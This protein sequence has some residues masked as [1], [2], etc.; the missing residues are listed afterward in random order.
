MNQSTAALLSRRLETRNSIEDTRCRAEQNGTV[1]ARASRLGSQRA[2]HTLNVTFMVGSVKGAALRVENKR[3][4]SCWPACVDGDVER[5]EDQVV[6]VGRL[7]GGGE[8][9]REQYG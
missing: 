2:L 1:S 8:D 6:D 7:L 3:I 5:S 9:A 4:R